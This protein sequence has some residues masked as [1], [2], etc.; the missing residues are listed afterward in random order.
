[1]DN[2]KFLELL[3][4]LYVDDEV[5]RKN[6][7][8]KVII[9]AT[10]VMR[11]NYETAKSEEVREKVVNKTIHSR[12]VVKAGADIMNRS[13][14]Q[15][16]GFSLGLLICF[17]HDIGR[18]PQVQKN[19]FS[20]RISGIDHACTGCQMIKE[21]GF[22]SEIIDEA[23]FNHS[24]KEYLGENIYAKL[25]RDADKLAIF[26]AVERLST[27]AESVGYP[28]GKIS[29]IMVDSFVDKINIETKHLK[30]KADWILLFGIWFW[31]LNFEPTKELAREEKIPE[32]IVRLLTEEGLA[33]E[34]L[35]RIK[36]GMLE[37][38]KDYEV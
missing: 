18:F 5:I 20:D 13:P 12:E 27:I 22:S 8:K 23:I 25:I 15:Q 4:E 36:S 32:R 28:R 26:R 30:T 10:G 34:E 9:G 7:P 21:A 1:M 19:T 3:N 2:K 11:E 24:R 33:A 29:K 6:I 37:F 31:D 38:K 35:R 17:L 14:G 16:W